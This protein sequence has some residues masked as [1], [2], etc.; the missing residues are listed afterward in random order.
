MSVP[1]IAQPTA[2]VPFWNRLREITRYPAH[3]SAMITIVLLAIGNLAVYLPFGPILIL[4]VTVAMYRFA[5]ECLRST[6]N[7]YMEPPEITHASDGSLGWKLI[8]LMLVFLFVA[9][10]GVALLGPAI[11][12]AL[13]VFLG[14]CLPGA[15]MTLAMDGS[16]SSALNPSKWI[17]IFTRIGWPYLAVVGLC[18]VILTSQM[19]AGALVATFLPRILALIV[20]GIISNYALVM[21]FHLMGYLIYQYSD[22]I[23]F[24]PEAPQ[25]VRPNAIRDL[26]QDVLDDAAELVRAG[27]PEDATGLLRVHMRGRGGTPAVHTQY[28]R[29]LGLANDRDELLR[30]GQESLSI[31]VAQGK[32]RQALDLLSECQALDPSFA[33]TESKEITQ[34]AKMAAQGGKP[35]LA[36]SLLSDFHKRFP[37]SFDVPQNGLLSATLMHELL[38]QDDKARELLEY[39]K[40][41]HPDD[42]LIPEIDARLAMIERMMASTRKPEVTT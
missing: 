36:I 37:R 40:D 20:V 16:L 24:Q 8:G 3:M 41:N 17:A 15:T 10:L 38:N 26:D 2:V 25:M 27:N 39:V 22:D 23:G 42:P 5:F 7:G 21:T 13:M 19:Y 30:H 29:L 34:L 12:V 14:V 1:P 11:G 32:E 6:A 31:L 4:L 28:R 35:Q 9:G 18:L 33:P